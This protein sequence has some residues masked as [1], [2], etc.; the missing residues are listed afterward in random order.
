MSRAAAP[1]S[2][3]S[4][5]GVPTSE[6]A[7]R[8][9]AVGM[10]KVL[11]STYQKQADYLLFIQNSSPELDLTSAYALQIIQAE[12]RTVLVQSSWCHK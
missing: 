6:L 9:V 7:E 12:R 11:Q 3:S 10:H 5:G 4:I 1:A 8:T 2:K